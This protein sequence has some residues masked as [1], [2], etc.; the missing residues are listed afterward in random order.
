MTPTPAPTVRTRRGYGL[1]EMLV[2]VT[3]AFIMVSMVTTF[4]SMMASN[5]DRQQVDMTL[6]DS[7]RNSVDEMLVS[8]RGAS[9]VVVSD[10][11]HGTAT[12]TS[13]TQISFLAPGYDPASS[14]VVLEN[15]DRIAY[16]YDPQQR[17]IRQFLQPTNGSIRPTRNGYVV[18]RNVE[19]VRYLYFARESLKAP[20]TG[21]VTHTLTATPLSK[22]LVMVNGVAVACEWT[23]QSR[24]VTFTAATRGSEVQFLY[25][26]QP[27]EAAAAPLIV[28]VDVEVLFSG[29]DG[30]SSTRRLLFPGSAR[31]RN[32]HSGA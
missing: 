1:V 14:T 28:Q 25:A 13:G 17:V 32:R 11:V 10:T 26:V 20:G 8:L 29:K 24:T 12:T 3:L 31:L 19:S 15:D 9:R 16:V 7:A 18:A 27:S 22:P 30:R 5:T 4:L 23:A 2:T 6:G 21:S